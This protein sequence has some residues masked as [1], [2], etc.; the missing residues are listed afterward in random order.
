MEFGLV[1]R[2]EDECHNL[3]AVRVGETS[4]MVDVYCLWRGEHVG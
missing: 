4:A 3:S 1:G 2:R